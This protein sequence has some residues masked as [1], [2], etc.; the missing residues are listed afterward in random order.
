M[1]Y[2]ILGKNPT[3][4]VAE[5]ASVLGKNLDYSLCGNDVL[6]LDKTIKDPQEL[7]NKLAGVIK[8]GEIIAEFD[9]FDNEKIIAA[10]VEYLKSIQTD[11][12]LRLGLSLYSLK[13][14]K[15]RSSESSKQ[16]LRIGLTI[17]KHIKQEGLNARYVTSKEPNLS[18]VV[19]TKNK[20]ID[21][22]A[23][24]CIIAN[25]DKVL[26]GVTQVVQPFESFSHRDYDR[27]ARD[28]YSGMLPPKIAQAMVN[29]SMQ[30][31]KNSTLLDP[32]CGSGTI[33]QEAALLG[34]QNIIGSDLEEKAFA[35]TKTNLDWLKGEYDIGKT[36]FEV[37]HQPVESISEIL[38]PKTVDVII[39][40]PL[41]GKPLRGHESPDELTNQ[42]NE[43]A[44]LYNKA[45]EQFKIIL[46]KDGIV[47][48][49][50]P[51]YKSKMKDIY[52][53]AFHDVLKL[54]F[55]KINPLPKT[56][57]GN[58]TKISPR[59]GIVYNR[60]GQRVLREIFVFKKID[61]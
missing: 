10:S 18:A 22:G 23:E 54:G 31:P 37:Y 3:L 8:I 41:L 56:T 39:T 42:A 40:E 17:K 38:K 24:F 1:N 36:E 33:L 25:G 16:L 15:Q 47:V 14:I 58:I 13:S 35:D 34:F 48:F 29:L 32:F 11:K 61:K 9:G 5:I 6:V 53:P 49:I 27:P 60:E 52:S 4:S 44:G 26:L 43:L 59:G 2:F 12:K 50:F 28:A 51:V 45:F 55:E 21:Q 57:P 19:V 7:Q 46:K 20:L 30:D